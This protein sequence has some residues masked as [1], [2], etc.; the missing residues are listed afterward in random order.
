MLAINKAKTMCFI[1]D[2]LI[3]RISVVDA[4]VHRIALYGEG[5]AMQTGV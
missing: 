2:P 4:E 1:I 3:H 5:Q